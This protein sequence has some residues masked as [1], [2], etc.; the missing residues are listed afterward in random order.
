MAF[1]SFSNMYLKLV[2]RHIK[3]PKVGLKVSF[4]WHVTV[5]DHIDHIT[6]YQSAHAFSPFFAAYNRANV[7]LA[8]VVLV[9]VTPKMAEKRAIT[10]E[11]ILRP[12]DTWCKSSR[13]MKHSFELS[14]LARHLL[15]SG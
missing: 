14:R 5:S 15:V 8:H 2:L 10:V 4:Y 9:V 12:L 1:S 13:M 6:P 11:F 7:S 3:D